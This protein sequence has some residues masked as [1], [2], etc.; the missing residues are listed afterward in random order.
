MVIDNSGYKPSQVRLT[1]ELLKAHVEHYIFISSIAVY[2]DFAKAGIDE[3]YKLAVA[4]GPDHRS[5]RT[6]R[7]TAR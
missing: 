7:P 4:Q 1:G 5:R 2:A 6:A 3:D